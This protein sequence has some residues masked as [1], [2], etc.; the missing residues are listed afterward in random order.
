[1]AD[2]NHTPRRAVVTG[3]GAFP[4]GV[5]SAVQQITG[6]GELLV[7]FSNSGLGREEIESGLRACI[8][9]TRASVVFTDLPG[10]SV[11]LAARRVQRDLP[12]LTVVTGANLAT[13]ID[14]VFADDAMSPR[15]AATHAAERGRLALAVVSG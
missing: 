9:A 10:G 1:M 14:F 8:D 2:E 3:H 13:L 5:V 7:A 11:T 4:E 12:Q 6:R 15:E